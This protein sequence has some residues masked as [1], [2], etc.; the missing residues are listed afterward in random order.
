MSRNGALA[1]NLPAARAKRKINNRGRL[2]VPGGTAIDDQRDAV[3]DL[4]AD[5][6]G[7]GAFGSALQVGRSG[8][9]G[10]TKALDDREGDSRARNTQRDVAGIGCGAQRQ[11]GAGPNDDGERT[12][13]KAVGKL[14]ELRIGV[15][16]QFVGLGETGDEQRKRLVLLARFDLVNSLDSLEI[17][18]I[19][20]ETVEGIRGESDNV[21]FAQ[22]GND[23]IDPV[24][25]RFIGMDAQDLRGQEAYLGS[26]VRFHLRPRQA[27]AGRVKTRS[28]QTP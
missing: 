5:A 22:T 25:L 21:A 2:G 28:L 19:D 27:G 8:S 6:G 11:L 13:P 24:R 17:D 26:R 12:G 3:S 20:G 1:Q 16:R 14:V 18:R 15:A 9:N 23:V 4:I 10:Q 7:V